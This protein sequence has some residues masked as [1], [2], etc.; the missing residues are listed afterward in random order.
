[1]EKI[2]NVQRILQL[3]EIVHLPSGNIITIADLKSMYPGTDLSISE[4]YNIYAYVTTEETDGNFYKEAYI[5]DNSG[6][7]RLRLQA[8]GGL[9][10]GDS[11]RINLNGKVPKDNPRFIDRDNWLPELFQIGVRNPQGM[12]LSP[13]DNEIYISNHGARGGDWFGRVVKSGNYGWKLLGWGGMNY[14]G[15]EIGPKWKQGFTRALHYWVPSIAVSAIAIYK[16]KEFQEWD[17][18][19]LITSLKD[20]SL[21]RLIFSKERVLKEQIIFKGKIGR[22]RDIKIEQRTGKILLLSDHG[23]LWRLEK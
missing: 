20:Q 12:Y 1:M 19:A 21:R 6:A 4:D 10:I 11:I 5:Q 15:T 13:Y 14:D 3:L 8:S 17:G 9:Y 7:I 16:G 2:F 22:I 23:A 18:Q